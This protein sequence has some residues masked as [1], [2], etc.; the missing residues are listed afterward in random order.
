MDSRRV[1]IMSMFCFGKCPV[2]VAKLLKAPRLTVYDA[3]K[4]FTEQGDTLDCPRSGHPRTPIAACVRK[5]IQSRV[6]R[7]PWDSMRKIAKEI[8][9]GRQSARKITKGTPRCIP[10]SSS[11]QLMT[12]TVKH[13]ESHYIPM[14]F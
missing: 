10:K 8:D 13:E 3:I 5:I 12:E 14:L 11:W 2:D 4:R 6:Q 1:A 7:S 9:L